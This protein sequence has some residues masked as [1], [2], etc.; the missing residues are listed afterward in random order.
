MSDTTHRG[1]A[2][3]AGHPSPSDQTLEQMSQ[4]LAQL[5]RFMHPAEAARLVLGLLYLSRIPRTAAKPGEPSWAWLLTRTA[6]GDSE[7]RSA[8]IKCLAHWLPAIEDLDAGTMSFVPVP[9]PGSKS[10]LRTLLDAI[11][12]APQAAPLLDQ[13]L[14]NLSAA[15]A[16]GSNYFTPNDLA[17]L[18]VG[19]AVPHDGDS[20]LDPVCGSGG[21]LVESHRYVHDRVRLEPTMSLWGRERH[22]PSCQVAHINLSVRGIRAHIF[23]PGDSLAQ[24]ESEHHDVILAN[25][26]FNQ[27][28]WMSEDA[29]GQGVSRPVLPAPT[30]PRW[31]V[32]PP[33]RGSANAAWIQHIAHALAPG[34]RA[35]FL[36]ADT[37]A[38]SRQSGPRR[39]RERLLHDDLVECVIALPPRVFGHSKA[40]GCLWVL[41]KDKR[42]RPGWGALD[43]RGQVLF[44][45]ARR[46]SERVQDSKM[47]RLGDKNTARILTTLAAWRG[48]PESDAATMPYSDVAG[49]SRS[50]SA[51][52]IAGHEHRLMPT[53]YAVEAPN[54]ELDTQNRIERLKLELTDQLAQMRDLEQRLLDALEEI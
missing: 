19:V 48:L 42:A 25:L 6:R 47:R 16:D 30:D 36:M 22:A 32:E 46:A 52:E 31:P 1:H 45:N 9:P 51:K 39:L 7:T 14:G 4:H 2:A 53:S 10:L 35:V 12:S 21:L 27:S 44:I 13:C 49:W 43:R 38:T 5:S 41:N 54:P 34:G 15:Q 37:V 40:T 33:P 29:T 24:P 50:C 23:P 17:R 8:V 20:V 28:A 26:P 11:A 18:M 3:R